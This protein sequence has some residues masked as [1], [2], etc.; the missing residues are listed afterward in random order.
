ME[1]GRGLEP[2]ECR[3]KPLAI[4]DIGDDERAPFGGPFVTRRK[5]VEGDGHE[6][7]ARQRL[8]RMAADI[9]RASCDEHVSCGHRSFQAR[10]ARLAGKATALWMKRVSSGGRT[11]A[12][13]CPTRFCAVA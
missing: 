1:H 3:G 13:L 6:A 7:G 4:Q 9:A 5:I 11:W 12:V 10:L 8:A 2:P